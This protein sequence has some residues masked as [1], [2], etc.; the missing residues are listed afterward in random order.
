MKNTLLFLLLVAA[1]LARGANLSNDGVFNDPFDN[2]GSA[3]GKIQTSGTANKSADS[4]F[5]D[6]FAD[7]APAEQQPAS[8][9]ISDPIEK[10]NRAFFTFN[11]KLYS[12]VL[13]PISR[14]FGYVTPKSFRESLDRA[15]V[16]LKYPVRGVNNLLE[17]H[18]KGAGVETARFVVN[19]TVGIGGLFDPASHWKLKP[20]PA[21][22]DQTLA[23][24]RIPSGCYLNI[25]ILGP[26]SV[27]GAV[28]SVGDMF[29][30]PTY[31]VNPDWIGLA[32]TG[33][34]ALTYTS[35]HYKEYDTLKA[36]TLDPYVAMRSAYFENRRHA[37][38]KAKAKCQ[39]QAQD[40]VQET[41]PDK[42]PDKVPNK[43][44]AKTKT[45][46]KAQAKQ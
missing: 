9:A 12:W 45:K 8:V 5:R 22:L 33:A 27:R 7:S 46:A 3:G 29:L 44:Q 15:F 20:H 38:E 24:Y 17:G 37:M 10:V 25:P 13:K 30:N 21:D 34:D 2:P 19:T 35:L 11:D 1:P 43:P 40:T 4:S 16:N 6:P 31:Y 42:V 39:D 23:T 28:G 26:S 18:F 41:A 14:G 36:G 32:V